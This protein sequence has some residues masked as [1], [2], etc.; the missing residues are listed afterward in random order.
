MWWRWCS[1]SDQCR[2]IVCWC[3]NWIFIK[4]ML[5]WIRCCRCTWDDNRW[6]MTWRGGGWKDCLT[7]L[8]F[9][10]RKEKKKSWIMLIIIMHKNF[11]RCVF[12][13]S[14]SQYN[15][16][17]RTFFFLLCSSLTIWYDKRCLMF[18]TFMS[19]RCYR[20]KTTAHERKQFLQHLLLLFKE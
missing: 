18:T 1:I 5:G 14:C 12:L 4:W 6:K 11:A 15:V 16:D 8:F 2:R 13:S 3:H 10:A 9:F 19:N 20:W 17:I 7:V